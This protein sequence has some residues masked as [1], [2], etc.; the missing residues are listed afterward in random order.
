[1]KAITNYADCTENLFQNLCSRLLTFTG[2]APMGFRKPH[3]YCETCFQKLLHK[4]I[5][6]F[7]LAEHDCENTF[8]LISSYWQVFPTHNEAR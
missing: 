1:M 3:V 7:Q 5:G 8:S 4:V 6:G 2:R